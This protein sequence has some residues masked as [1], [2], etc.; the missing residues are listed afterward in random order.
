MRPV[1][2]EQQLA[3]IESLKYTDLRPEFRS[4]LDLLMVKL[5]DANRVK[6]IAGKP[7]SAPMLLGLALEYVE[8]MNNNEIPVV[9]S[10]FERVVQVESRRFVE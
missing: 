2:N 8:A 4:S 1:S 9:L 3:H 6:T 5:K 10:S 7:L